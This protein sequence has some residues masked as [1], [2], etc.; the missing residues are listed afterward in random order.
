MDTYYSTEELADKLKVH[1][2]T[3]W[4]WCK[5]GKL[6]PKKIGRKNLFKES[7]IKSLLGESDE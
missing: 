3:I 4:R 6:K 7:D 1:R 5:E 2:Q